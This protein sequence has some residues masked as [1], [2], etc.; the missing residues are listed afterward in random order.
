M[1]RKLDRKDRPIEEA[2]FILLAGSD[3]GTALE[4]RALWRR[5]GEDTE[6]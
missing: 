1:K 5:F 4:F 3:Y 2:D 6:K